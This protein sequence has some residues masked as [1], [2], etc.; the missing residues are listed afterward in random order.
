MKLENKFGNCIFI[1]LFLIILLSLS[2]FA[3]PTPHSIKGNLFDL[4]G[5]TEINMPTSFN[6]TNLD[7][8]ISIS[9]NVGVGPYLSRYSISIDGLDGDLVNMKF[10]N[11][12]HFSQK[13]VTLQG[14]MSNINILINDS[15][16]NNPPV[17][18][19][20]PKSSVKKGDEYIYDIDA[21][22]LQDLELE[23]ELIESPQGM[24]INND[25]ITWT[26]QENGDYQVTI[27]VTDSDNLFTDQSFTINVYEESSNT[28]PGT[29][30]GG[31]IRNIIR[32]RIRRII[33]NIDEEEKEEIIETVKEIKQV[34]DPVNGMTPGLKANYPSII[35]KRR[36]WLTGRA[37]TNLENEI[38]SKYFVFGKIVSDSK[39]KNKDE[40]SLI[41]FEDLFWKHKRIFLI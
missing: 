14:V 31:Y 38:P 20:S 22:D 26:S 8:G 1:S 41:S 11:K 6:I 32:K 25:I 39:E 35:R 29:S 10:R 24:Q 33:M 19:S 21:I 30:R 5:I 37:I 17:I 2:V 34:V 9:G 36:Q 28:N 4:D 16:P 3:I 40:K 23:Y 12:Y 13:N 27:R 18:L 7:T 15:F